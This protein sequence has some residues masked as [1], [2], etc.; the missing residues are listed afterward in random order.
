MSKSSMLLE[1]L[2]RI[3]G[4][5]KFVFWGKARVYIYKAYGKWE[6][7]YFP[8]NEKGVLEV[9]GN[10]KQDERTQYNPQV[11]GKP[12]YSVDGKLTFKWVE[13]E[14]FAYSLGET[15]KYDNV[16][17]R[18]YNLLDDK[19]NQMLT[20]G[21]AIGMNR[22]RGMRKNIWEDPVFIA[23]A[24]IAILLFINTAITYLGIEQ[25]GQAINAVQS[26]AYHGIF[27]N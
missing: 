21:I 8:V 5:Q 14:P 1:L 16:L 2:D 6:T 23:I 4:I 26:G 25:V 20:V 27:H 10:N 24:A 13:G 22:A 19:M 7:H 3:P 9:Y 15:V 18:V 17:K 12:S 11:L